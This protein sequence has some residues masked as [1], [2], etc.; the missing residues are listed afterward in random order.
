LLVG[1][2]EKHRD[3]SR[4]LRI[5]FVRG[6]W[7]KKKTKSVFKWGRRLGEK[8]TGGRFFI[9]MER[10]VETIVEILG[11]VSLDKASEPGK[12]FLESKISPRWVRKKGLLC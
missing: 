3:L 10:K 5:N 2:L 11:G 6:N 12:P 8:D 9:Y 1:Y 4:F 7:Q